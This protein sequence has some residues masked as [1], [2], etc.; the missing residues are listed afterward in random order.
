MNLTQPVR[1]GLL[2]PIAVCLAAAVLMLSM[3]VPSALGAAPDDARVKA[4]A[5]MLVE[6]PAGFG[7]PI[8]DRA[9]WEELTRRKSFR[10]VIVEAQELLDKPIP[11]SPDDLY[12]DFSRTGNRTRWQKVN[13]ERCRRINRL[14]LAECLENK[15]RFISALEEAVRALCAERTWVMPAHDRD[16]A[17]FNGTRIDIDLGSARLAWSL[18]TADYLLADK[19]SPETRGLIRDHIRRRIFDPYRDMVKGKRKANWWMRTTNNWNAVCLA[20]VTGSALTLLESPRERAF[21]VAAAELYSKNFLKGFTAD[22]YCS[23]GVGYWNYGFG[24]YLLLAEVIHQATRGSVDLLAC[25]GVRQPAMYGARIEIINGVCPA[26]AD[27]GFGS[28]P[29]SRIMSMVSRRFGLGLR[30]WEQEDVASPDG[31]LYDA[32]MY[33]FPNSASRTPPA[34]QAYEGPGPRTWFAQAGILISRPG[35]SAS[36]RLGV[37]LKGGHNGEHHNHN[38]VG[39]YVVVVGAK[40]VLVDPGPEVYTARTFSSHRYDSNLLNSFGHSVP[41]VAGQLQ[42]TGKKAHGRVLRTEFTDEADTL[43]LDIRSAYDVPALEKLQRTFVYLRK[44]AGS[45]TVTDEVA[46][47][48]PQSFGTALITFGQWKQDTPG[49]LSITEGG[50][51]IQ[52]HIESPGADFEIQAD[53]IHEDT[54]TR[55]VPTRLG[56]NLNRPVTRAS[57]TVRIAPASPSD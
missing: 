38:D 44:G 9:A 17:N 16:L 56:I 39:S 12:L 15:G 19:L 4:V 52:V 22:G 46:F 8:S 45:L 10:Q 2:G 30:D 32:M 42:R 1:A 6:R 27:C 29:T 18:A 20:G 50:E 36:C 21:F 51:T 31:S 24:H 55:S 43:A 7:R 53:E 34:G 57:V 23:E 28:R 3:A 33:T 35:K 41:I 14:A 40:A 5:A 26:F 48:S 49:S 11:D 54:A 47:E 13:S 25:K 37:A